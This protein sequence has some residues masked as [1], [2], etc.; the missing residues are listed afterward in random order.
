MARSVAPSRRVGANAGVVATRRRFSTHTI[1]PTTTEMDPKEFLENDEEDG[2]VGGNMK[3]IERTTEDGTTIL[4][5]PNEQDNEAGHPYDPI[6]DQGFVVVDNI[7]IPYAGTERGMITVP[8]FGRVNPDVPE[9]LQVKNLHK[10]IAVINP[11]FHNTILFDTRDPDNEKKKF[12]ISPSA[13]RLVNSFAP[14]SYLQHVMVAKI[15]PEKNPFV[16]QQYDQ[17]FAVNPFNGETFVPYDPLTANFFRKDADVEFYT[18]DTKKGLVSTTDHAH[19]GVT[20][21]SPVMMIP[22]S[23]PGKRPTSIHTAQFEKDFKSFDE[24]KKDRKFPIQWIDE[25][26][27]VSRN[28]YK[29]PLESGQTYPNPSGLSFQL[30]DAPTRDMFTQQ[31]SFR[32]RKAIKHGLKTYAAVLTSFVAFELYMWGGT[33]FPSQE[34]FAELAELNMRLTYHTTIFGK[35]FDEVLDMPIK[36]VIRG[37][38]DRPSL[39]LFPRREE[40]DIARVAELHGLNV[41]AP[42]ADAPASSTPTGEQKH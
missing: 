33:H 24:W 28:K 17:L 11:A 21:S 15:N 23:D 13:M 19:S 34:I 7:P 41:D 38:A 25:S 9:E 5:L 27:L 37:I 39:R 8:L 10:K 36:D 42:L 6:L 1:T 18:L 20:T 31:E 40:F 3:F 12:Q 29:D 32:H 26:R 35:S 30:T 4:R 22:Y 16:N 14:Y 2:D